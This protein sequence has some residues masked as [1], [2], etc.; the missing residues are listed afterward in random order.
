MSSYILVID[1]ETSGLPKKWDKPYDDIDNWPY[2]VQVSWLVYTTEGELV[3]EQNYYTSDND[4]IITDNAFKIHGLDKAFLSEHGILRSIVLQ[5]LSADI[6][7]YNPL[8]VGHCI[9]LDFHVLGA[10]YHRA[11]KENP[12]TQLHVFCTML[13]TKQLVRNPSK[14]FLKLG[15]LYEELFQK[16]LLNQHNALVDARATANCFFELLNKH[17]ITEETIATQQQPLP[18][19]LNK[20]GKNGLVLGIALF[21]LITITAAILLW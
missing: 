21:F 11:N 7:Q 5:Q 15:E 14:Q 16:P 19:V 20:R 18:P 2:A 6:Q 17:I 9:E 10:A 4:F 13:S 3:K 1:T 12:L 8:I